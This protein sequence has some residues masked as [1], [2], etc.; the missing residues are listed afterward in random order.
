M[1]SIAGGF[2]FGRIKDIFYENEEIWVRQ[3]TSKDEFSKR[4]E[5][6]MIEAIRELLEDKNHPMCYARTFQKIIDRVSDFENLIHVVKALRLIHDLI[7]TVNSDRFIEDITNKILLFKKLTNYKYYE[8]GF[9]KGLIVRNRATNI[10]HILSDEK[11]LQREKKKY[12]K[13][14]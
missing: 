2:G 4:D 3:A 10:V 14:T 9:E 1:N 8:A 5:N 13:N 12:E 7:I 11:L 6:D